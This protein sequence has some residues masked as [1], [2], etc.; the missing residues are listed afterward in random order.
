[1]G[2]AGCLAL[3]FAIVLLMLHLSKHYHAMKIRYPQRVRYAQAVIVIIMIAV[4]A[5]N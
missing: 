1:L 5:L 3:S 2:Y 4:F